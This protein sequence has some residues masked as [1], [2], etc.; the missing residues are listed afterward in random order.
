MTDLGALPGDFSVA[1]D[2]NNRGWI[3]GISVNEANEFRGVLWTG[4][5][6]SGGR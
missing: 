6:R 2:I 5:S 4:R 3:A 1:T